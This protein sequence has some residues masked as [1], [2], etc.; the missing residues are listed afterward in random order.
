MCMHSFVWEKIHCTT[1]KLINIAMSCDDM[2]F[3]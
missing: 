3:M 1:N 2:N